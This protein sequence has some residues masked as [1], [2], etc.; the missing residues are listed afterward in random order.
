MIMAWVCLLKICLIFLIASGE[1]K[2][3]AHALQVE[4]GWG[5]P[6]RSNSSKLRAGSLR[7][8]TCRKAGC[9]WSLNLRNNLLLWRQLAI[10]KEQGIYALLAFCYRL[11]LIVMAVTDSRYVPTQAPCLGTTV[12][13]RD[14]GCC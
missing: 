9:K 13:R 11:I 14:P 6:L 7:R 8:K 10:R 5:W 2:N 12:R 4:P 1:K 3:P